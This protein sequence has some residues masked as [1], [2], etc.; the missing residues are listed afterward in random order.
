MQGVMPKGQ[1]DRQEQRV[2]DSGL[3][4]RFPVAKGVSDAKGGGNVCSEC[5]SVCVRKCT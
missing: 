1:S 2:S 5:G 4:E 3:G